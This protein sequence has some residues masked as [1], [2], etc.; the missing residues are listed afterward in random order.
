MKKNF[1]RPLGTSAGF[2]Y[3][4]DDYYDNY[5]NMECSGCRAIIPYDAKRCPKCGCLIDQ[6]AQEVKNAKRRK[7]TDAI[8]A[9]AVC[10]ISVVLVIFI[11][12]RG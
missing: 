5:T 2:R 8:I 3:F 9:L 6:T 12:F 1:I 11:L 10:V 4:S 7:K